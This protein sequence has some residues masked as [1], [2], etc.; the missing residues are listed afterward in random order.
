MRDQLHLNAVKPLPNIVPATK[1]RKD[2]HETLCVYCVCGTKAFF[3][4]MLSNTMLVTPNHVARL[5]E[6]PQLGP[7]AFELPRAAEVEK[8]PLKG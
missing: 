7:L 6:C 1:K 4:C 8:A 2:L 3:L 5:A